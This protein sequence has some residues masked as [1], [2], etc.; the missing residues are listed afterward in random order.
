MR[1]CALLAIVVLVVSASS[2]MADHEEVL[3][4]KNFV[5]TVYEG[6]N[7]KDVGI[8]AFYR[9]K[10]QNQSWQNKFNSAWFGL[11][12]FRG[13]DYEIVYRG[14]AGYQTYYVWHGWYEYGLIAPYDDFTGYYFP[15]GEFMY[16][17]I[18]PLGGAG[19]R[20]FFYGE[21]FHW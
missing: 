4:Y 21:E 11:G 8:L 15:E 20:F 5:I 9:D 17:W 10:P 6:Q 16:G 18:E 7:E 12:T 14:I 1:R 13:A 3:D 19:E 2:V